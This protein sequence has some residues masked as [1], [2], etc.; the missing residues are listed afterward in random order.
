LQ[1]TLKTIL[2][3]VTAIKT[4]VNAIETT[5]NAIEKDVE[6][7]EKTVTDIDT[8]VT[9]TEAIV[10]TID[11]NVDVI[12][13]DQNKYFIYTGLSQSP[14]PQVLCL[15]KSITKLDVNIE[16]L[17][18]EVK[19]IIESMKNAG[20]L[21]KEAEHKIAKDL[22]DAHDL[23]ANMKYSAACKCLV[24]AYGVATKYQK[25]QHRDDDDYRKRDDDDDHKKADD[26]DHKKADDDDHKKADD[27]DH[28][29]Q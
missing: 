3:D 28:K 21:P 18:M 1:A 26:D 14:I 24:K 5:V 2:D 8:V 29:K 10:K 4:T 15:P 17:E 13:S 20:E 16:E 7:I 6:A 25:D 22:G 19:F 27:D 23:L 12:E 11:T 9:Q